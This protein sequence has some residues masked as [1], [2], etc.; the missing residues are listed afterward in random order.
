MATEEKEGEE[1]IYVA[2][3]TLGFI[4]FELIPFEAI[5]FSDSSFW[6]GAGLIAYG[7]FLIIMVIT[8]KI[9]NFIASIIGSPSATIFPTMIIL[10]Y[11]ETNIPLDMM[12][13]SILVTPLI[14]LEI[15]KILR[16]YTSL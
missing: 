13:L 15:F 14:V 12:T 8:Q 10:F 6:V 3:I 2:G 5:N 4:G 9:P 16:Q 11:F 1:H 7:L